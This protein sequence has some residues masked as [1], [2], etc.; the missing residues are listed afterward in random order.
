MREK[1]GILYFIEI[2]FIFYNYEIFN[3][4][5]GYYKF[6]D[7]KV[8]NRDGWILLMMVV[9]YDSCEFDENFEEK[10]NEIKCNEIV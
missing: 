7:I 8:E 6:L 4:V 2:V 5:I 1:W 9:V 3:E 10:I